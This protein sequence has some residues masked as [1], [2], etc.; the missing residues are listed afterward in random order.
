[1]LSTRPSALETYTHASRPLSQV[2]PVLEPS[3]IVVPFYLFHP[4]HG[5]AQGYECFHMWTVHSGLDG[6][7][8]LL[9]LSVPSII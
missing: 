8:E 2:G 7:S 9:Y 5:L 6:T 1:M 3:T 4:Y